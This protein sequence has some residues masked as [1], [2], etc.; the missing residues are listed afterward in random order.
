MAVIKHQ[1]QELY[2]E[3][4]S[5]EK[6]DGLPVVLLHSFLCSSEMWRHQIE[7]LK[8]RHHVIAIDMRGHGRS[9][10]VDVA[11]TLY[12]LVEDAC[13][14]LTFL[15]VERA[16]WAGLSI[17]GMISMRAALR[18][19]DRV[20]ALIL[21]DTHGGKEFFS[22]RL[23]YAALAAVAGRVGLWPVTGAVMPLMFGKSS[24]KNRKPLVAEWKQRF[25]AVDVPS[26]LMVLKALVGRDSVVAALRT[27]DIPTLVVA[28]TE[29]KAL[30]PHL[31]EEI[32]TAIPK[33]SYT[34]IASAGHLCALERPDVVNGIFDDFL[35]GLNL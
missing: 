10:A 6:T 16:V 21:F 4:H 11:P 2:F 33:A 27:L 9:G 24:L 28:G 34:E 19:P 31:S 29:D 18:Y 23:K 14:V 5:A 13:A 17:G 30:P 35:P 32:A 7:H 12:D 15:G 22:I 25:L 8:E 3:E 1:G 20:A 26:V